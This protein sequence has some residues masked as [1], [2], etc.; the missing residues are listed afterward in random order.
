MNEKDDDEEIDEELE[1][2]IQEQFEKWLN[3]EHKWG[4]PVQHE[5]LGWV[6]ECKECHAVRMSRE[7]LH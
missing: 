4:P 7:T 6:R 3:C 5:M 2:R 1:K